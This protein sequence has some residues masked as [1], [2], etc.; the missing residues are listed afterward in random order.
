MTKECQ[1]LNEWTFIYTASQYP[2]DYMKLNVARHCNPGQR[3]EQIYT[4]TSGL[5]WISTTEQTVF[6]LWL[7]AQRAQS[8]VMSDIR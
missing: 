7:I 6:V 4:G 8:A 2:E 5:I 1:H 3:G